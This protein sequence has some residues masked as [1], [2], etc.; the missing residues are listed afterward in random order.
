MQ[1]WTGSIPISI[2]LYPFLLQT[3]KKNYP[4]ACLWLG[5]YQHAL[6]YEKENCICKMLKNCFWVSDTWVTSAALVRGGTCPPCDQS[7]QL[8]ERSPIPWWPITA[9]ASW[10][11]CSK[12]ASSCRWGAL[13]LPPAP[14][15]HY[16]N[17]EH[18][19]SGGAPALLGGCMCPLHIATAQ[20]LAETSSSNQQNTLLA[21]AIFAHSWGTSTFSLMCF[22]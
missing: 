20:T 18:G 22:T 3:E 1:N 15:A 11:G 2:F 10:S 5:V 14:C 7:Y 13:A 12:S 17:G 4:H 6:P 8:G 9:A 21:M 19:Q 16:L